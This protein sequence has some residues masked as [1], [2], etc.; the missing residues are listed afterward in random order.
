MTE[1]LVSEITR[2]ND[3]YCVLGLEQAHSQF[4]S[5]RPLPR[6]RYAWL[7]FPYRRGDRVAFDFSTAFTVPP[8]TEDRNAANDR[9][10]GFVSESQLIATLKQAE[11]AASV[12]ELFGC[13]VH[14]SRHGG[15][16]VYALPGEATRSI[17]GCEI[18]SLS[19]CF[20]FYPKIRASIKLK[21]GETLPSVPLVDADWSQYISLLADQLEG[22]ANIR[23]RLDRLFNSL[24]HPQINESHSKFVRIGLS[25]PNRDGLCWFMLDSLFPLPD[26]AWLE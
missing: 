18:A 21:S 3:G 13:E 10:I 6:R 15:D 25:R 11:L 23:S 4:R 1:L 22:P 26:K 8:H 17:C 5:V 20:H 12:K 19:F 16:S 9:K 24:V 2:M 14:T 7:N